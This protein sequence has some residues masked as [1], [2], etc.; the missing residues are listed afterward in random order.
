MGDS[1][2]ENIFM[3]LFSMSDNTESTVVLAGT[4]KV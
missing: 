3:L 1:H 2:R 4:V